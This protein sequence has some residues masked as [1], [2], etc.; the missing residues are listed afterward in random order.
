MVQS[1]RMPLSMKEKT[2][3][4]KKIERTGSYYIAII[5]RG[6]GAEGGR[7]RE[8]GLFSRTTEEKKE[9]GK[10]GKGTKPARIFFADKGGKKKKSGDAHVASV[11]STEGKRTSTCEKKGEKNRH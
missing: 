9:D 4:R 2:G 10:R 3:K 6:E 1:P 5:R 11:K 8:G 7:K